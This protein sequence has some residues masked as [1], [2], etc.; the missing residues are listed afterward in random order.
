MANADDKKVKALH[1]ALKAAKHDRDAFR[2]DPKGKVP[3]LDDAAVA[4]FKGMSDPEYDHLFEVDGEMQEAGFTL[5]SSGFS[6][7][8]V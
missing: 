7:R 8:M 6:V 1:G 2:S 4:V 3:E 5:A